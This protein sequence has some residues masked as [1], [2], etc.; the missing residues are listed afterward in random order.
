[1]NVRKLLARLNPATLNLRGGGGGPDLT[2]DDIAGALGFVPAGLGREVLCFLWWPLGTSLK[3]G[4]LLQEVGLVQHAELRRLRHHLDRAVG[5]LEI[6]ELRYYSSRIATPDLRAD[7]ERAIRAR[8]EARDR[9]WPYQPEIYAKIG[10]AVLRE[11]A[12]DHRCPRCNGDGCPHCDHIGILP[13]SSLQRAAA[14]GVA[15]TPY[16]KRWSRVYEFTYRALRDA[17]QRA[18]RQLHQA[19]RNPLESPA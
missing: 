3:P 1:M 6:A 19:L 7:V 10:A 16:R 14:I 12:D 9:C 18:A 15:E 17:E 8:D 13:V 4:Q 2:P 5:A 11:M